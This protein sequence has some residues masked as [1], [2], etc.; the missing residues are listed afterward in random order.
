MNIDDVLVGSTT[1]RVLAD[2][3]EFTFSRDGQDVAYTGA[4]DA[5]RPVVDALTERDFTVANDTWPKTVT[6]Q[7]HDEA[8]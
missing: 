4:G 1:V 5:P 7:V 2:G 3:A 8:T 6:V